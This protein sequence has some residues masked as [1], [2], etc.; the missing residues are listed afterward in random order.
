VSREEE[1]EKD[2]W[3]RPDAAVYRPVESSA[4]AATILPTIQFSLQDWERL[5][6]TAEAFGSAAAMA[7]ALKRAEDQ[8]HG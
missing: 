2:A 4:A 5:P 8:H 3:K 1:E 6:P 7:G